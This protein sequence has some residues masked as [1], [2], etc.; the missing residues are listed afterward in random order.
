MGE[1]FLEYAITT[2]DL[3]EREYLCIH[4][5]WPM[6][7]L[8]IHCLAKQAAWG[9]LRTSVLAT[10]N[11]FSTWWF[12]Y[13]GS[14]VALTEYSMARFWRICIEGGNL[15]SHT[16]TATSWVSVAEILKRKS[17]WV[18]LRIT[19][20][21]NDNPL[22]LMKKFV[23]KFIRSSDISSEDHLQIEKTKKNWLATRSLFIL[24]RNGWIG[25]DFRLRQ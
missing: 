15:G 5:L 21:S 10:S 8:T 22:L 11:L 4:L 13:Q 25:T 9:I 6:H 23:E 24:G 18:P 2:T 17:A 1:H 12:S 19:W 14:T 20:R 7:S 16:S 3:H